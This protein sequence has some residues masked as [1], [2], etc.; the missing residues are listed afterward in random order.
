MEKGGREEEDGEGIPDEFSP[1]KYITLYHVLSY[2][3]VLYN[4]LWSPFS[5]IKESSRIKLQ[6]R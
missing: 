1:T 6:N 2:Y 5:F 4:F 3:V